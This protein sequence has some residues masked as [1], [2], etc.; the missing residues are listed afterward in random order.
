MF[1]NQVDSNSCVGANSEARISEQG[2]LSFCPWECFCDVVE[3]DVLFIVDYLDVVCEFGGLCSD[4]L[5]DGLFSLCLGLEFLVEVDDAVVRVWVVFS[6]GEENEEPG[7]SEDGVEGVVEFGVVGDLDLEAEE[8]LFFL[9]EVGLR[10][11]LLEFSSY[12]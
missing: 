9:G 12:L 11:K 7:L 2:D 4:E 10:L 1:F 5:I 3:F 8:V 6:G